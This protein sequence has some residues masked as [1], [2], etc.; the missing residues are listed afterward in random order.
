[1]QNHYVKN[2]LMVRRQKNVVLVG[3]KKSYLKMK[4]IDNSIMNFTENIL[5]RFWKILMK[6]F[7]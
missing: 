3:S 1:M 7:H 4:V 6:I 2:Y 5:I